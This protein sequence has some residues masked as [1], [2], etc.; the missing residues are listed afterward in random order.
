MLFNEKVKFMMSRAL[1]D[2]MKWLGARQRVMMF[3]A[4]LMTGALL[5]GCN[6]VGVLGGP[7]GG[8]QEVAARYKGLVDQSVAVL[9]LV[10]DETA[11]L[12]SKLR[13]QLTRTVSTEISANV[14]GADVVN[15]K[16]AYEIASGRTD[17]QSMPDLERLDAFGVD[18]LV[19]VDVGEFSLRDTRYTSLA[20]GT[21]AAS[22]FVLERESAK[23]N[24]PAAMERVH[25][26]YP[27]RSAGSAT[28]SREETRTIILARS[29]KAIGRLFYD[30]TIKKERLD[31]E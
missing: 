2:L 5:T 3:A 30:H 20:Q 22:V 6:V 8:K 9:V 1:I 15:P 13:E 31:D 7:S 21:I 26:R 28:L 29:S 4:L 23:L 11:R 24:R 16:K 19:V 14:M 25:T 18:R 12:D 17:W 10:D 27:D